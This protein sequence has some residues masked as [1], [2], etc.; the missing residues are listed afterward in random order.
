[1]EHRL[2]NQTSGP[3]L[4]C[5]NCECPQNLAVR[6]LKTLEMPAI[7]FPVSVFGQYKQNTVNHIY[8]FYIVSSV[9]RM[10]FHLEYI[11][12]FIYKLIFINIKVSYSI[13]KS[14]L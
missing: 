13:K 3:E 12:Y 2:S 11:I 6:N 8:Y 5:I 1:M 10:I 4:T 7:R 9:N 14:I